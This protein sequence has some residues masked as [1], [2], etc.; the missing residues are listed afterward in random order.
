M[1]LLT[2]SSFELRL[3]LRTFIEHLQLDDG[4]LERFLE[5]DSTRSAV[6]SA[7]RSEPC[8]KGGNFVRALFYITHVQLLH[9]TAKQRLHLLFG[10]KMMGDFFVVDFQG[11]GVKLKKL[12]H[13]H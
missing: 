5:C 9:T 4:G 11:D 7:G 12:T 2:G 10:V 13:I 8:K 1:Q 3:N 6:V